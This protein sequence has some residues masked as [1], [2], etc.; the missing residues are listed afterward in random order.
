MKNF[1]N[2]IPIATHTDQFMLKPE[3][4]IRLEAQ[5]NYTLIYYTGNRRVLTSKVLKEYVSKL[6]PHGFLRTHQTHLINPK[7]IQC[8]TSDNK[9]VL[10]D[11]SVAA[12]SRRMK[13][14]VLASLRQLSA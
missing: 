2:L 5:S 14:N 1:E 12:V 3:D 8:I 6:I 10:T 9:V 11:T 7:Y 13:K 4:I